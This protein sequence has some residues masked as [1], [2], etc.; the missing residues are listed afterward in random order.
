MELELSFLM[1]FAKFILASLIVW[2]LPGGILCS[3]LRLA[4]NFSLDHFIAGFILSCAISPVS[5]F[6]IGTFWGWSALKLVTSQ[7]LLSI[8]LLLLPCVKREQVFLFNIAG[9]VKCSKGATLLILSVLVLAVLLPYI[10]ISTDSDI[11]QCTVGDWDGREGVVWSIKN[12][13]LPL[14]DPFFYPGESLRM[15]YPLYF[16]L[17]P[18]A[19]SSIASGVPIVAGWLFGMVMVA[20]SLCWVLAEYARGFVKK[21]GVWIGIVCVTMF[22]GGFDWIVVLVKSIVE[23]LRGGSPQMVRHVDAWASASQI[24]VDNIYAAVIWAVPH[25]CAVLMFLLLIRLM[26]VSTKQMARAVLAG[27]VMAAIFGLSPYVFT[28]VA[29][30]LLLHLL[31]IFHRMVFKKKSR[32]LLLGFLIMLFVCTIILIP[33]VWDL[34]KADLSGG[35]PKLIARVPESDIAVFCYLFGDAIIWRLLD[36][37]IYFLVEL[38]PILLLGVVGCRQLIKQRALTHKSW[39]LIWGVLGSFVIASLFRSTGTYNDLGMRV[40]L[41][42]QAGLAMFTVVA[43][44]KWKTWKKG[45]RV[46][47]VGLL[48]AGSFSVAW[49]VG[50]VG[51]SRFILRYPPDRFELYNACR[52]ISEYTPRDAVIAVDP[53]CKRPER[54]RRWMERRIMIGSNLPG[55]LAYTEPMLL[56]QTREL[57]NRLFSNSMNKAILSELKKNN[58][59]YML[60]KIQDE[61]FHSGLLKMVYHNNSYAVMAVR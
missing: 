42:A 48:L 14:Q 9:Y 12:L 2:I 23:Y 37:L 20:I 59:S 60:L 29:V 39:Y 32:P 47:V 61:D 53:K 43:L 6:M 13:G 1:V 31:R 45:Y 35:K 3:K 5:L 28:G 33:Y 41:I 51:L 38:G 10:E 26:P 58:V 49:E 57:N 55:S 36:M 7:I 25:I 11:F 56:R 27:I 24:R 54:A 8:L 18:A 16:Y 34:Q 19:I 22:V 17:M 44:A 4:K 52:Y 50:A 40:I 21:P 46:L 15:Y 30:V